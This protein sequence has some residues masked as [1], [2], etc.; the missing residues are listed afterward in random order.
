MEVDKNKLKRRNKLDLVDDKTAIFILFLL[1]VIAIS[2]IPFYI[3]FF[4]TK[5]YWITT[6]ITIIIDLMAFVFI[7][8]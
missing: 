1:F 3:V 4:M 6:I 5:N 8:S 7:F 2:I